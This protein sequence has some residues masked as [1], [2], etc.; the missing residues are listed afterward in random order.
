LGFI[1]SAPAHGR[2]SKIAGLLRD[3]SAAVNQLD[4]KTGGFVLSNP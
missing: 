2:K 4:G 1:V 3:N